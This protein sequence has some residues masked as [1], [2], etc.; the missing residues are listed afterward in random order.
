[1]TDCHSLS[2]GLEACGR[3]LSHE[4]PANK[5]T[6]AMLVGKEE[7]CRSDSLKEKTLNW[8]VLS[9]PYMEA[10]PRKPFPLS[11]EALFEFPIT[12]LVYHWLGHVAPDK[13]FVLRSHVKE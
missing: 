6:A 10:P 4:L 1:M 11:K 9:Q 12:A 13:C 2:P 5:L 3:Y 8:S 7:S